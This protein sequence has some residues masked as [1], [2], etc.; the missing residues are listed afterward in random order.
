M[1]TET[2]VFVHLGGVETDLRGEA[3]QS[4]SKKKRRRTVVKLPLTGKALSDP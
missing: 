1:G 2:I 4:V 3:M